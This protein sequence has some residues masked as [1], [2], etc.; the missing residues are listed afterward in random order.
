MDL[1]AK[2]KE[3]VEKNE[4]LTKIVEK[5]GGP[6]KITPIVQSGLDMAK[7]KIPEI[8]DIIGMGGKL[9]VMVGQFKISGSEK[10]ELVVQTIDMILGFLGDNL[11]VDASKIAEL[12]GLAKNTLPSV[13]TLAVSAA[14]GK[15][16]FASIKNNSAIMEGIKNAAHKF[17]K[18]IRPRL[19][20]CG[21]STTVIDKA[22]E[23]TA[24][25]KP[26]QATPESEPASSPSP[27]PQTDEKE[28]GLSKEAEII[29][30]RSVVYD[31]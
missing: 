30:A 24:P 31:A 28:P 23:I 21:L 9:A 14:K 22:E 19:L 27:A 5:I 17:I 13:L 10:Q 20:V 18:M 7:S 3:L 4:V 29:P 1:A 16:D 2:I 26:V 11:G 25:P 8:G 6:D 12:R 15:M